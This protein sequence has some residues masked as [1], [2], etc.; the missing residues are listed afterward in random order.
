M[1]KVHEDMKWN[2]LTR[3]S[4]LPTAAARLFVPREELLG[5]PGLNPFGGRSHGG[6]CVGTDDI[7]SSSNLG[8]GEAETGTFTAPFDLTL[9]V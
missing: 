2:E 6:L 1:I 5:A 7:A 4:A 9:F 8:F 3:K